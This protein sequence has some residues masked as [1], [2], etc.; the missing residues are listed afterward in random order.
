MKRILLGAV[1]VCLLTISQS[2]WCRTS[3]ETILL[4]YM[5]AKNV[6]GHVK[7]VQ[8]VDSLEL[9]YKN[10]SVTV[11]GTDIAVA[12]FKNELKTLDV[13]PYDF[14][15]E[16]KLVHYKVEPDGK[17]KKSLILEPTLSTRDKNEARMSFTWGKQGY[18]IVMTPS[19][20]A[21]GS[22]TILAYVQQMG[23]QGEIV[24][25]GR[26]KRQ[27]SLGESARVVGMVEIADKNLR[28][29]VMKGDVV[30]THSGYQGFY[31]EV[32]LMEGNKSLLR[33]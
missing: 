12:S 27:M 30:H 28:R 23:K 22:V 19:R 2:A 13:Q 31:V 24:C 7:T 5:D 1:T 32:R 18:A 33:K 9:N 14:R 15:L 10:N 29:H 16:E 20:N 11:Q 21:D 6:P 3:S 26:N 4:Q 25:S 8:G 17:Y